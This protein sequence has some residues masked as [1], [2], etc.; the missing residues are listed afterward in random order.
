MDDNDCAISLFFSSD[1]ATSINSTSDSA[2]SLTFTTELK[3]CIF[4][5]LCDALPD[6]ILEIRECRETVWRIVSHA[7]IVVV[8][9]DRVFAEILRLRAE[10]NESCYLWKPMNKII[11]YLQN[12]FGLS[13][14]ESLTNGESL[15][16]SKSKEEKMW[17]IILEV[18]RRCAKCSR[19]DSPKEASPRRSAKLHGGSQ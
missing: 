3:H 14:S 7:D 16:D 12:K 4:Q 2:T 6:D 15:N 1:S 18:D 19:G 5:K 17:R 8:F 11:E 13:S 9:L 10:D